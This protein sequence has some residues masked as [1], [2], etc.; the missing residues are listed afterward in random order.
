MGPKAGLDMAL[1]RKNANSRRESNP[2]HRQ[3]LYRLNHLL[4]HYFVQ[5]LP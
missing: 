1:K 4:N 2:Y 5:I 3:L